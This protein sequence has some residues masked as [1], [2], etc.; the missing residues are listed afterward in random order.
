METESREIEARTDLSVARAPSV[1]LE[2]A[3]KAAKSLQQV[4]ST[5]K[6]PVLLNGEQYLEFEDWQTVGRFYGVTAKVV[7][8]SAIQF[9]EVRGFEAR[10]VAIR[11]DTG[12]EV[13]AAESMCLNDEA[14]WKSKPL[15][16]LRSM[17]QTRA[18][19]KAL[20]NVL[21]W[22]V[23]LAGY[24]PTPAEEMTGQET[25]RRANGNHHQST[26]THQKLREAILDFCNGDKR[27]AG[28]ILASLTAW[29]DNEGREHP[30]KRIIE[31][32]SEKMAMVALDRFNKEFLVNEPGSEG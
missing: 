8:T 24:K 6:K 27:G 11:T 22:V 17:A 21:A 10:A 16:Q 2:E 25:Q 12:E 4:I 31:E 29:K 19:A 7:S 32:C 30:G 18:C 26:E 3:T 28:D 15:F 14:N 20:R 5:K 13:S 23:V 1:V 9:E